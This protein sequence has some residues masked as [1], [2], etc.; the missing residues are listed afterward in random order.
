MIA[1][2]YDNDRS[3]VR[4]LWHEKPGFHV[5]RPNGVNC[6]TFLHFHSPVQFLTEE[7]FIITEPHA[8]IVIAPGIPQDYTV[9]EPLIHD[10]IHF[11]SATADSWAACGLEFNR[12]Y[13]PQSYD[14]ISNL[15]RRV[16]A[17]ATRKD[18]GYELMIE[19]ELARIFVQIARS[20]NTPLENISKTSI[21][22]L[23]RVRQHMLLHLEEQWTISRLAKMLRISETYTY[24]LYKQ[25]YGTSP[26]SD[27]IEAR[28]S[29]AQHILSQTEKSINE[30]ALSLGYTS[31]YHFSR[32]FKKATG[33]SPTEFR[34]NSKNI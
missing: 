13:Y 5:Y 18:R 27:L 6:Y 33:L 2:L 26:I 22:E 19:A 32:Q 11:D 31:T 3:N 23:Q 4:H 12:F 7:G 9:I 10:W 30:I 15:M 29:K 24:I 21:T 17:E 16:E 20:L 25:I 14:Y 28:I 1:P 8:C 34:N